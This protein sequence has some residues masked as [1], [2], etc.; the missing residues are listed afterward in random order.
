[1]YTL[2]NERV[3]AARGIVAF[4]EFTYVKNGLSRNLETA[5]R[6][7]RTNPMAVDS[8][9]LL[10]QMLQSISISF[11]EDVNI[12]K[13]RVSDMALQLASTLQLTS[14]YAPGKSFDGQFYG[15]GTTEVLIAHIEDFDPQLALSD[16]QNLCP[17]RV[18]RH[19][20][21]DLSM[22]LP[23][24]DVHGRESGMAVIAINI[25]MLA[26]QWRQ[27]KITEMLTRKDTPFS[28]N[29]F[30]HMY[31]LPNMLYSHLDVAIVNRL[32]N[33]FRGWPVA[34]SA[35]TV[36][37]AL[38]NYQ[39]N[40]DP[41]LNR[42]LQNAQRQVT[43]DFPNL[44]KGIPLVTA[45]SLWDAVKLP[46]VIANRQV[47]WALVL[48]RLT[49]FEFLIQLNYISRN[50]NNG[51]YLNAIRKSLLELRSDQAMRGGLNSQTYRL[52]MSELKNDIEAYL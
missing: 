1:M 19:P 18:L 29:Q 13:D 15:K 23:D 35:G 52:V 24:G 26:C 10:V 32:Y 47:T 45:N 9:H 49:V 43:Y 8:S 34:D 16:W 51:M 2:L 7:Y 17:V 39:A 21:S 41:V 20:R 22:V 14:A 50:S 31:V 25:P 40:L 6:Y 48:A 42:V 12:Y 44:L 36:P 33:L 28:V 3:A 37:F 30:I 38:P 4:P 27:F 46:Q 5:V 11:G